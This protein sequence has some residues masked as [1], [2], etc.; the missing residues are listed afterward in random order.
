MRVIVPSGKI[1]EIFRITPVCEGKVRVN[2]HSKFF[3][4]VAKSLDSNPTGIAVEGNFAE[5]ILYIGNLSSG[6]VD[7]IITAVMSLGYYDLSTF[8][9]Q[10][11]TDLQKVV[12]DDGRSGA[13]TSEFTKGLDGLVRAA[14][15]PQLYSHDPLFNGVVPQAG[16]E[17]PEEDPEEEPVEEDDDDDYDWEDVEDDEED[18]EGI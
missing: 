14:V 2:G 11:Q 15:I 9:Y 10:R 4:E 1:V 17:F 6:M 8:K 13:Y 5:P 16:Q 18:D 3:F 12:L 7:S